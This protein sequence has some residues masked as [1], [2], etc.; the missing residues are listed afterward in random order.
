MS[1]PGLVCLAVCSLIVVL[2]A[3][4]LPYVTSDA[5]E[6]DHRSLPA[7]L[8]GMGLVLLLASTILLRQETATDDRLLRAVIASAVLVAGVFLKWLLDLAA[9]KPLALHERS[10]G[11]ALLLAALVPL[12]WPAAF[13][14]VL[15]PR[16]LVVWFANGFFWQ[17]LVGDLERIGEPERRARRVENAGEGNERRLESPARDRREYQAHPN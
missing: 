7:W 10:F 8:A 9:R 11:V 4:A 15:A 2:T 12:L 3:A 14:T 17:T 1:I 5:R 16:F 6:S 13:G